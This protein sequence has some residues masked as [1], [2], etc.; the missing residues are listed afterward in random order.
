MC[1][2][3][4]LIKTFVGMAEIPERNSEIMFS[5]PFRNSMFHLSLNLD[6]QTDVSESLLLQP[7][8]YVEGRGAE[9]NGIV[10][11]SFPQ[12]EGRMKL[13]LTTNVVLVITSG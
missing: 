9:N 3:N 10:D 8:N 13:Y 4:A 12:R 2:V 6:T 11:K 7:L 5:L 1:D